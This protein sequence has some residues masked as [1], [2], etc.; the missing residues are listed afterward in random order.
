[1]RPIDRFNKSQQAIVDACPRHETTQIAVLQ[2]F[3]TEQTALL[4]SSKVMCEQYRQL[5]VTR[6]S[7]LRESISVIE[8]YD[9]LL[10]EKEKEL[11]AALKEI[12]HL[13]LQPPKANLELRESIVNSILLRRTLPSEIESKLSTLPFSIYAL[14]RFATQGKISAPNADSLNSYLDRWPELT[15]DFRYINGF[16]QSERLAIF[17]KTINVI[18][19]ELQICPKE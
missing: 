15:C 7:V 17:D 9:L 11:Q 19:D 14:A 1:M 4:A 3:I 13:K 8:E 16:S 18:L 10:H 2:K 6:E 5:S 12:S